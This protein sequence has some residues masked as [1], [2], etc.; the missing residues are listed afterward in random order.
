MVV[1]RNA[2]MLAQEPAWSG[3]QLVHPDEVS[4]TAKHDTRLAI[5]IVTSRYVPLEHALTERGFADIVPFYDLAESFRDR[6]PLSNGWFAPPLTAQGRA[7][8][9]DGEAVA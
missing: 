8:T 3:V 2:E 7:A 5:S 1:D 4:E 6:H 9:S